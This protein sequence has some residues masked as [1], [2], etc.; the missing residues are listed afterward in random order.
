MCALQVRA[1]VVRAAPAGQHESPASEEAEGLG[2][3]VFIGLIYACRSSASCDSRPAWTGRRASGWRAGRC[4]PSAR[5]TGRRWRC[6]CATTGTAWP[7]PR[8]AGLLGIFITVRPWSRKAMH[9]SFLLIWKCW[10]MDD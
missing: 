5:A 9:G 3:R 1:G 2:S 7:A 8:L 10:A 6:C 4:N